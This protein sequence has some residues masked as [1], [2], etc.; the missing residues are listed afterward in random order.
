[1]DHTCFDF[2]EISPVDRYRLMANAVTPRPVAFVTTLSA[3][4]V[5]NAAAFSFFGLLSHDPATLAIGI[6][7]RA[8]GR[9]KDTAENILRTGV[10]TVHIADAALAAQMEACGAPV[11]PGVD[12]LAMTGL[13]TLPGGA[14]DVPRIAEAPVAM[15]CRLHS[16]IPLG[17]ARDVILGTIE[18]FYLRADSLDA[19]GRVDQ[20][21]LDPIGRVGAMSY[22]TTRDRFRV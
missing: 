13:A 8:D 10:F 3:E 14:I 20:D 22:C 2:T 15:E 6:E 1:M 16:Q 7:P 11:E 21:R 9:R 4:G 19:Q 5:P 12:E 17:P 18:R